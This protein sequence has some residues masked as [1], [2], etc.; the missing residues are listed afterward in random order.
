MEDDS[1]E[2]SHDNDSESPPA[3]EHSETIGS[4]EVENEGLEKATEGLLRN[5]TDSLVDSSDEGS[6]PE[7]DD[8]QMMA[9]DDQLA[10]IFKDR[11]RGKKSK[12][13]QTLPTFVAYADDYLSGSTER[14]HTL[15]ES[16]PRSFKCLR[17]EATQKRAYNANSHPTSH[18]CILRREAA[19]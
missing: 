12:G 7:L 19:L 4:N 15:Q 2:A 16:Y 3:D 13:S 6:D 9:V 5:S 17:E 10:Q 11:I 14:G 1:S 18:S 8:D